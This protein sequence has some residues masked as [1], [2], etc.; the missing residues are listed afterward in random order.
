[1]NRIKI[2]KISFLALGGLTCLILLTLR[3]T[4]LAPG[5]PSAD[6]YLN[7]GTNEKFIGQDEIVFKALGDLS[8]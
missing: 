2:I 4:G 3:A 7:A 1:M 8:M 5:H 6:E